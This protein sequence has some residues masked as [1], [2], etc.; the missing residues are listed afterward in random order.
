MNRNIDESNFKGVSYLSSIKYWS[1]GDLWK[2][3]LILTYKK[4]QLK[5]GAISEHD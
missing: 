1:T 2:K 5:K 4:S 3:K